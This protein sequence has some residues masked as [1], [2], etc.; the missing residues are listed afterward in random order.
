MMGMGSVD[1]GFGEEH[2]KE[3]SP[4]GT[5]GKARSLAFSPVQGGIGGGFV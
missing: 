2:W 5:L 3:T 1:H 4:L